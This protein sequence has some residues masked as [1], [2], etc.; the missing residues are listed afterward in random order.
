MGK[1]INEEIKI[2]LEEIFKYK[3]LN[4]KSLE[5][6]N[7]GYCFAEIE[8]KKLLFVGINPSYLEGYDNNSFSYDSQKA[9]I[10]YPKYFKKFASLIESTIY[11]NIWT[12]L[13]IFHFR[14]TNQE[15]ISHLIE[16]DLDFIIKQLRLTHNIINQL[17]P[18]II[19]VCNSGASNFFG[20]NKT[21]NLKENIET[22]I[23]LGYDFEF[24]EDYGIDIIKGINENSL[25]KDLDYS[26][27]IGKPILFTSTLTYQDKFN[28]KRLSWII[29]RVGKNYIK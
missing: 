22:N 15:I 27:L 1:R 23:W 11:N 16:N 12:Y 5:I 26:N 6:I 9:V 8:N 4:K 10:E 28:K 3:P 20:I 14:E 18:E 17:N 25:V 13:D 24:N 29:N 19:V 7:R 21:Q 2:N